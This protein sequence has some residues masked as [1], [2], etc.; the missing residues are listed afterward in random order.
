MKLSAHSKNRLLESLSLYKV[1]KEYA[2]PL[3]NY[4]V[5]G[6][7]PGGFWNAVLAND[8]MT[9]MAKS[10]PA[11]TVDALKNVV[12]WIMNSLHH[13]TT[14]GSYT[15]VDQ[16]LE[17]TPEERRG[18]L[19]TLGLIYSEHTE[20]ILILKETPTYEPQLW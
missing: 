14:H 9:A 3:V 13:G 16:W 7:H 2:D 1:P 19:E 5:H 18:T 10:H 17:K 6:F 4:L 20:I 8:F 12:S 15:I 11:N